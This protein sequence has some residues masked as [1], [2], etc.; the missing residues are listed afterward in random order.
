[1]QLHY[2]SNHWSK[3]SIL[4]HFK[5]YLLQLVKNN[6]PVIDN[7]IEND[8]GEEEEEEEE[9]LGSDLEDFIVE[10]SQSQ[11]LV[12]DVN[13]IKNNK[14]TTDNFSLADEVSFRLL[15]T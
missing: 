3:L 4:R 11:E 15:T 10:D 7:T 12:S 1:M 8:Q 2:F 6:L 13:F 14:I 9:D 5:F